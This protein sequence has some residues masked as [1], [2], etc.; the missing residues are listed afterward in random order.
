[1]NA[2]N[3]ILV[4][5][6]VSLYVEIHARAFFKKRTIIWQTIQLIRNV[7]NKTFI[8]YVLHAIL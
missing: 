4:H 8:R 1:M 5:V 2:V 3:S 6:R 7:P